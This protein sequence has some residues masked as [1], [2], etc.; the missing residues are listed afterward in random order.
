MPLDKWEK[1]VVEKK[2]STNTP[3]PKYTLSPYRLADMTPG[4]YRKG[5]EK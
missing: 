3:E 5:I 2:Q 1:M 4:K